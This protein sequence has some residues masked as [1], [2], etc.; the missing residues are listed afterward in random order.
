MFEKTRNIV[1]NKTGGNFG[2]Q[3]AKIRNQFVVDWFTS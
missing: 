2:K 1:L 3:S